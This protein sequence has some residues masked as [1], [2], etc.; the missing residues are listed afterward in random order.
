MQSI[1]YGGDQNSHKQNPTG[2]ELNL[3]ATDL[4]QTI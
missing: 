2:P 3:F 1:G 4:G